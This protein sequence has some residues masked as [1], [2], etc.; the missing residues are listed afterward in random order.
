M[1]NLLQSALWIRPGGFS[2]K[3]AGRCL[4]TTAASPT[5]MPSP[6]IAARGSRLI[7]SADGMQK[8]LFYVAASRGRES[9]TVITSDKE[10]LKE[11][12]QSTSPARI[13]DCVTT[14]TPSVKVYEEKIQ[15]VDEVQ[16]R[17]VALKLRSAP[18]KAAP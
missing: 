9:V 11:K 2:S 5:V 18:P 16:R 1:A 15:L 12:R 14:R 3:M 6:P 17:I 10:R 4:P 7:I 8:E 13:D